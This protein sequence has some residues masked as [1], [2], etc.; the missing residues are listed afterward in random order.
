MN[1]L[2][3]KKI[4]DLFRDGFVTSYEGGKSPSVRIRTTGCGCWDICITPALADTLEE[5]ERIV[6]ERREAAKQ[7]RIRLSA[8]VKQRR[9]AELNEQR[10]GLYHSQIELC[11]YVF[12]SRG[13]DRRQYVDYSCNMIADSGMDAYNKTLQYV[14]D[15]PE[16][17]TTRS[18][19]HRGEWAILE[20]ACDP[21]SGGY[22]FTFLGVKTDEG[23]SLDK[24]K[25]RK[26]KHDI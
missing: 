23:Y 15:H 17:L 21:T 13:N 2:T 26:G 24:W 20:S 1:A 14:K 4:R 19:K 18:M 12:T 16:E 8:A 5:H 9:L 25:E 3:E 10:R 11:L 22:V 7:E 6:N